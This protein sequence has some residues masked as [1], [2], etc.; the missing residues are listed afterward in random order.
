MARLDELTRGSL[1]RGIRTDGL[2]EVL[3]VRRFG[4]SALESALTG[5]WCAP[6]KV[7]R[8]VTEN[9]RTLKFKDQGFEES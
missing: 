6:D 7:V 5:N 4:T 8:T 3:D 2:V 9:A 1:L